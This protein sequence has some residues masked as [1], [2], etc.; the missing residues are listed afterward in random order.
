M[1]DL[2]GTKIKKR[3]CLSFSG[4]GS[5]GYATYYMWNEWPDREN[6]DM[7]VVFANTGLEN[8]KTLDFVK[9]FEEH[10][11][12]PITWVEGHHRKPNGEPY[13]KK[14]WSVRHKIVNYL[15]AARAQK[16]P[17]G[18]WTWTPFEELLSILGIPSSNAPFCSD[19][20][21]R[22][23]IEDYL[24]K[25]GFKGFHKVIGIRSDEIDRVKENYKELRIIY[26]LVSL[27]ITKQDVNDWWNTQDFKLEVPK[28]LGN[29]EN[30]WKKNL[31][32][33]CRNAINYPE[34]WEWWKDMSIKYGHLNPRNTPLKPPF[35]FYRGNLSPWDIESLSMVEGEERNRIAESQKLDGCSESCEAF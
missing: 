19:Q 25:T 12:I 16:L 32:A 31:N 2:F 3:L 5:S 33:L 13:S 9:E 22:K 7:R 6:W 10:F 34:S 26:P 29:C 30:C 24:N 1:V 28:D 14:G 18:E 27:G 8:K 17:S 11:N 23:V 4:G 20:L 15:K 21:K 35:N